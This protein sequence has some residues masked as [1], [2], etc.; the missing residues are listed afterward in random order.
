[1]LGCAHTQPLCRL[2]RP[3]PFVV[4]QR[5]EKIVSQVMGEISGTVI[6]LGDLPCEFLGFGCCWSAANLVPVLIL[7]FRFN[8]HEK[9]CLVQGRR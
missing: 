4:Y 9:F 7:A 8:A 1:M 5:A 3:V 6:S 2:E